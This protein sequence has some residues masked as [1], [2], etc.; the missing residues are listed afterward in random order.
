MHFVFL[1]SELRGW[2][3]GPGEGDVAETG[4]FS[5]LGSSS[6]VLRSPEAV[7]ARSSKAGIWLWLQELL[8][9]ISQAELSLRVISSH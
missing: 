2:E 6:G 7:P 1:H 8:H 3:V 5:D 9:M 4:S